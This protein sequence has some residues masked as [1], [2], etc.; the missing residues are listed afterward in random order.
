MFDER[1]VRK[2]PVERIAYLKAERKMKDTIKQEDFKLL[3]KAFDTTKFH[4][5]RD[6]I[7]TKLLLDT[8]MRVGECLA[9]LVENVDMKQKTILLTHSVK[10]NKERYVYFSF[11]M[12]DEL[13]RW[14]QY[15]DRNKETD[16]LFPSSRGNMMKIHLFEKNLRET[17]RRVGL[18][19]HPHQL[20]NNFAKHY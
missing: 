6:Y 15:K 19:V 2:N 11:K 14:I 8:G 5:Y 18:K 17:A 4:G 7:I 20:R 10:G 12:G 16:L 13:R 9:L 3:P 1:E